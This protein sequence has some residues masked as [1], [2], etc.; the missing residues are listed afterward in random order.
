MVLGQPARTAISTCY[1]DNALGAFWQKQLWSVH[2]LIGCIK[3]PLPPPCVFLYNVLLVSPCS[4]FE[5]ICHYGCD[6]SCYNRLK[7][8]V[9]HSLG[10][11][12]E[13]TYPITGDGGGGGT[14]CNKVHNGRGT[15]PPSATSVLSLFRTY[16]KTMRLTHN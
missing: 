2:C 12:E 9:G 4:L 7:L 1:Q 14:M 10:A 13:T 8:L 3:T 5:G 6:Y 11:C 16:G 15:K